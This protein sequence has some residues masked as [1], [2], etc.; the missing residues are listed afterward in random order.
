MKARVR[1]AERDVVLT[2][3]PIEASRA[4][5]QEVIDERHT[6]PSVEAA[7]ESALIYHL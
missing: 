4:H 1:G 6:S 7:K 3:R 2:P 5:T